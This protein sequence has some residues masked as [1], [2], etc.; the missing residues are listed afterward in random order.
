MHPRALRLVGQPGPPTFGGRI[1]ADAQRP[2]HRGLVRDVR[3]ELNDDGRRDTDR[4]SVRELELAVDLRCGYQSGERTGHRNGLAV[5]AYRRTLPG[6]LHVKPERLGGVESRL[7]AAECA[8]HH[9]AV[10]VDQLHIPKPAIGHG[11]TDRRG[12]ID[13]LGL[14]V[15]Q[16]CQRGPG[17]GASSG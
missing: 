2:L 3:I 14:V 12:R 4:L 9:L 7:I 17:E 10:R 5:Q 1:A 6:V 8:G 16:E 13:V 11:H 15:G